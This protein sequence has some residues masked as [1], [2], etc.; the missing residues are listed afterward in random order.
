M[1]VASLRAWKHRGRSDSGSSSR[2]CCPW[3]C[4]HQFGIAS[5]GRTGYRDFVLQPVTDFT[6][7]GGGR[8]RSPGGAS[9]TRM[10]KA[11]SKPSPSEGSDANSVR[12]PLTAAA[13]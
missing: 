7:L 9:A 5:A 8:A 13:Y 2:C 3:M 6:S 11:A 4:E 12:G 10:S 1:S